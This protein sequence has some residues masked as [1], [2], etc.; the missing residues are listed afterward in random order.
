M[1]LGFDLFSGFRAGEDEAGTRE[2]LG[3]FGSGGWIRGDPYSTK[4]L[5]RY[6]GLGEQIGGC[7]SEFWGESGVVGGSGEENPNGIGVGYY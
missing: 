6:I 1:E 4:W 7:L 2:E 5:V 3:E